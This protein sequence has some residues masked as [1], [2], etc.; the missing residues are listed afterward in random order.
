[1]ALDGG[2]QHIPGIDVSSGAGTGRRVLAVACGVCFVAVALALLIGFE[3]SGLKNVQAVR[4]PRLPRARWRTAPRPGH[5]VTPAFARAQV[6]SARDA[7]KPVACVPNEKDNGRLVY[8]T[9]VLSNVS[10]FWDYAGLRRVSP[11]QLT[12][13]RLERHAQVHPAGA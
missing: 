1:M 5:P 6:W 9:C 12:G 8:A 2:V 11:D 3:L 10:L 13:V 4:F 7:V